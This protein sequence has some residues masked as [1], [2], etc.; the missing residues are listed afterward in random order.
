MNQVVYLN[1]DMK[2]S[3]CC[4]PFLAAFLLP[5]SHQVQSSLPSS[6]TR[7]VNT[8][9]SAL[10]YPLPSTLYLLPSTLKQRRVLDDVICSPLVI[11]KDYRRTSQ[12]G[13]WRTQPGYCSSTLSP[14]SSS[15]WHP[16]HL[17]W[18]VLLVLVT[19]TF[20][21]M[22]W[23]QININNIWIRENLKPL[24]STYKEIS[25]K[26]SQDVRGVRDK[27]LGVAT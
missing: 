9:V 20:R 16:I 3:L 8:N 5:L 14:F 17:W 23:L 10:W 19:A 7:S 11:I 4:F 27:L 13:R 12:W 15:R 1:Q 25:G 18:S 26:I 22:L 21:P 24:S 6:F 2:I